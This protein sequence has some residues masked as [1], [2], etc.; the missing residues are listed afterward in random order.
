MPATAGGT[1]SGSS[2]SVMASA[3]PGNERVASSQA[4]GVPSDHDQRQRDR[5]D[6]EAQ[7]QRVHR[8]LVAQ[9]VQ[10]LARSDVHE[11][12][13][14]RQRQE[15]QHHRQRGHQDRGEARA[16]AHFGGGSNPAS[17]RA[18]APAPS[19]RPSMNALAASGSLAPLDHRDAVLDARLERLGQLDR[20]HLAVGG[21]DV[22]DV[23]EACVGRALGELADHARHVGLVGAHVGQDRLLLAA[24]QPAQHLA[25]VGADGHRLG[26]DR[27]L[28]ARLGQ[29]VE[30]LDCRSPPARRA[31][32]GC[33]RRSWASRPCPRR[34]AGRAAW[35]WRRR[36]RRA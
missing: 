22:G 4:A 15:R 28:D 3:R 5:G 16:A 35:C 36:T 21:H 14:Q 20:L 34:T 10:Q 2:T 19:V 33:R 7:H 8:P 23:D 30:A 25:R 18:F 12:R 17:S 24:G 26:A 27:Q 31:P 11:D 1:T 6:L 32:A 9:A 13:H 29:V